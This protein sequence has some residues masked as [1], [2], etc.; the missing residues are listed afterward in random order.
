[1]SSGLC[2]RCRLAGDVRRV[3]DG[4]M[5]AIATVPASGLTG[6]PGFGGLHE[7]VEDVR[8]QAA[9]GRLV[10]RR[11]VV[12]ADPH[13]ADQIGGEADEPG[14]V[15]ILRRAGLAG[16][17]PFVEPRRLAGAGRHGFDHQPRHLAEIERRDD[18]ARSSAAAR[19]EQLSASCPYTDDAVGR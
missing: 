11:I 8:R 7:I 19:E 17:G 5:A 9:A 2:G 12:I 6:K 1:M 3:G 16:G 15:E 10:H 14:V 4:L 13:A 18:V